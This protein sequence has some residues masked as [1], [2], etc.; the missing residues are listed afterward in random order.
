MPIE[1]R[2]LTDGGQ[3]PTEIAR[4]LATFMGAARASLDIAPDEDDPHAI[5]HCVDDVT[6]EP[7]RKG[8]VQPRF[9]LSAT[10]LDRF[11]ATGE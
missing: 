3:T 5:L 10:T 8:R 11:I 9:K 2:T 4:E 7:I 1:L 6:D